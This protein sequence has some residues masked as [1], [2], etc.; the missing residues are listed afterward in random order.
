M[1]MPTEEFIELKDMDAT[2]RGYLIY[3][4]FETNAKEAGYTPGTQEFSDFVHRMEDEIFVKKMPLTIFIKK[5]EYQKLTS[6]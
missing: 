1:S 6:I 4:Y 2:T 3:K 5:S